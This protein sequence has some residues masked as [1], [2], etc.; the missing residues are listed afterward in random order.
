MG[1]ML[2]YNLFY[3]TAG[4]VF[5]QFTSNFRRRGLTADINFYREHNGWV[6]VELD[7]GWE[8]EVSR[9]VQL[10]VS[11]ALGCPGFLVFVYDGD[12]W[13][14][15]F[16]DRGEAIDHF[17]QQSPGEPVGFPGRDCRGNPFVLAERMPF[18][19]VDDIAP[20]LVQKPEW[21][22]SDELNIPA[23]PGDQSPRFGELAVLDFLR[24]LGVQTQFRS[25]Y[26]EPVGRLFRSGVE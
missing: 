11:D 14:Y 5:E 24:M 8:W 7:L 15:E 22:M 16:F 18:L 20:Y 10:A 21:P 13:G 3:S 17:V 4:A 19:K 26:I 25:G 9:A 1:L 2:R 12:Y 6:V 23:R